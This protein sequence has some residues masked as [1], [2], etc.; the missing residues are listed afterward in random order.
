MKKNIFTKILVLFSTV[1]IFISTSCTDFIQLPEELEI[2]DES[3]DKDYTVQPLNQGDYAIRVSIDDSSAARSALPDITKNDIKSLHLSIF[4]SETKTSYEF[5]PWV[6][7]ADMEKDT[8]I[9]KAGPQTFTLYGYAGSSIYSSTVNVN[10]PEKTNTIS[11]SMVCTGSSTAVYGKGNIDIHAAFPL[12]DASGEQDLKV[13]TAELISMAGKSVPGYAE[14]ELTFDSAGNAS[15]KK[16]GVRNGNYYVVFSFYADKEKKTRIGL[17]PEFVNVSIGLTSSS[18]ISIDT[19]KKTYPITY[20]LYGNGEFKEGTY[21]PT[22]YSAATEVLE[23]PDPTP[24]SELFEFDGWYEKDPVTGAL[25]KLEYVDNSQIRPLKLFAKWNRNIKITLNANGGKFKITNG[26]TPEY[27]DEVSIAYHSNEEKNLPSVSSLNLSNPS[28]MTHLAGWS[29]SKNPTQFDTRNGDYTDAGTAIFTEDT[30][31]YAIYS[32]TPT[33]VENSDMDGDG[34]SDMEEIIIYGTDPNSSDT[35]GDGWTDK[36]ELEL[37]NR[38][39]VKFNPCIADVPSIK[40]SMIGQ[41]VISY[42][43]STSTGKSE[44]ETV[45]T[46]EG[47]NHSYSNSSS[48]GTTSSATHGWSF[49]L[50]EGW[51]WGAPDAQTNVRPSTKFTFEMT[52]SVNGSY[53]D[54]S[55][56]SFSQG[57]CESRSKTFSQGKAYSNNSAKTVTG[58]SVK[59][60]LRVTNNGE[61]A[62]TV[63]SF[64][65]TLYR[66]ASVSHLT[67]DDKKIV[68][69]VSHTPDKGFSLAPDESVDLV[70]SFTLS[71]PDKVEELLSRSSGFFIAPSGFNISM[72]DGYRFA[73]KDFTYDLTKVRAKTARISIDYGVENKQKKEETYFVSTKFKYNQNA[74][75]INDEYSPVTLKEILEKVGISKDAGNLT[76][77]N[78]KI[79]GIKNVMSKGS[80]KDG[81]WYILHIHKTVD[82]DIVKMY[83]N[84]G[85]GSTSDYELD[86]IFVSGQ[87]T[88][89]IFYDRDEDGDGVPLS[90]ETINGC[91]DKNPD[92][93][94]DGLTDYQE[95]YGFERNGKTYCTNP[96]NRDTDGD[97]EDGYDL[98]DSKDPDPVDPFRKDIAQLASLKFGQPGKKLNEYTGDLKDQR[99]ITLKES[100]N[101]VEYGEYLVL[102]AQGKYLGSKLF[103]GIVNNGSVAEYTEFEN[104]VEIPLPNGSLNTISLKVRSPDGTKET[105]YTISLNSTYNPLQ[106]FYVDNSKANEATVSWNQYADS[107][108]KG[109]LLHVQKANSASSSYSGNATINKAVIENAGANSTQ[110]SED[111]FVAINQATALSGTVKVTNIAAGEYYFFALY[112]YGDTTNTEVTSKCLASKTVTM[113]LPKQGKLKLYAHYVEAIEDEDGTWDPDYYWTFKSNGTNFDRLSEFNIEEGGAIE[114]DDDDQ[115]Y[116]DFET[117]TNTMTNRPDLGY[118]KVATATIDRKEM[119]NNDVVIHWSCFERDK[120]SNDS[121]GTKNIKLTYYMAG[122]Y[123]SV[124]ID[125]KIFEGSDDDDRKEKSR[126]TSSTGNLYRDGKTHL[127]YL[128]TNSGD[129]RVKVWL[130]LEWTWD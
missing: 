113:T 91:S 60:T 68:S 119:N 41:P 32:T 57:E 73:P 19:F 29:K 79:T 40:L 103:Y 10:I 7:A 82:G 34:I 71:N 56:Y 35:D 22:F 3:G 43:F 127:C 4:N 1:L 64:N 95:L 24:Y 30:T 61:I 109:Y 8:I 107:R 52:Q 118:T 81:D 101:I 27:K 106:G 69:T 86:K 104:E 23:L 16:E 28:G 67:K 74:T 47:I 128:F 70:V 98:S 105:P 84:F 92:S 44:S 12:K 93:D 53:S 88:V 15:Y 26:E 63:N 122:D 25:T 130:S 46:S 120:G 11:F 121:L 115:I 50:K 108:F 87:D 77:T 59:M 76:L 75:S 129:G 116:Y 110:K 80:L 97:S 9:V 37:Y 117:R 66:I 96:I 49:G 90:E 89:H 17:Y 6:D 100:G 2:Y 94:G 42:N 5:G 72:S 126:E 45:S 31:L 20:E 39:L 48:H 125:G 38:D 111:F 99:N 112:G 102:Q 51:E 13:V 62:Y 36:E 78:G 83:N 33:I 18:D 85:S 21:V 55:S 123:W 124:T 14:E 65:A 58:G 54:G 114:F